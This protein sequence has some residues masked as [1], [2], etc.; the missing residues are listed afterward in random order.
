MTWDMRIAALSTVTVE[1]ADQ[2]LCLST[3]LHNNNILQHVTSQEV[4]TFLNTCAIS[5][6]NST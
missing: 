4:V 1:F 6:L 2:L 3:Q 5:I